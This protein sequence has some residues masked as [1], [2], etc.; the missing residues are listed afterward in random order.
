MEN[1]STEIIN[2][3]KTISP[4]LAEMEKLNVFQ[5]PEGYFSDL[6]RRILTSILILPEEKNNLQQV[7]DGYFDFLPGR[8]LAKIKAEKRK[9]LK[10][11]SKHFLRRY[12][13]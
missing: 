9:R 3:L 6:H 7:P 2:E 4:L 10:K 8:I 5:V 1:K 12:I 11:K 13:T